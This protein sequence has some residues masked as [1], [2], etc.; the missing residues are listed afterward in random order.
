[1]PFTVVVGKLECLPVP[2]K[3]KLTIWRSSIEIVFQLE[4]ATVNESAISAQSA[5]Y[6][7]D[8]HDIHTDRTPHF[9]YVCTTQPWCVIGRVL[10]RAINT[11]QTK[12]EIRNSKEENTCLT[13]NQKMC[14]ER[15]IISLL[16]QT[17]IKL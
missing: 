8:S 3:L 5:P 17:L 2:W 13:Q 4:N 9:Q 6:K 16:P 1:M 14:F 10:E 15:L 7:P 11:L 12:W